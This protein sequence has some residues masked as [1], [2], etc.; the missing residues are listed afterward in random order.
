MLSSSDASKV[1]AGYVGLLG[2]SVFA[3]V[4]GHED[5]A[6]TLDVE[7]PEGWP[8]FL[9]LAPGV[10]TSRLTARAADSQIV[11][12]PAVSI[13]EIPNA[14]IP[15]HLLVYSEGPVDTARVARLAATAFARVAR[16]FGVVPL[17]HYTILQE[18]LTPVSPRHNYNF[19]M[20]HLDSMT[21]ALAADRALTAQSPAGDEL[22]MQFN[23]AHH[24]AHA[25]VPKRASGAGYF[26]F[27]WELA[28][29]I[30]TI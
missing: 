9:T 24:I 10:R 18:L 4:E 3:Y 21:S 6:A 12:G 15:V 16:Y 13:A 22:R 29:L 2:Y 25:W 11:M 20:E 8:V 17:V 14:G 7:G 1:R 26:P 5:S 19:S 23:L 28:P 30:D 27:Q